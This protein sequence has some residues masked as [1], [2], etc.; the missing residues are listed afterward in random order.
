MITELDIEMK[1]DDIVE[2]GF[3]NDSQLVEKL[4]DDFRK[5]VLSKYTWDKKLYVSVLINLIRGDVDMARE[6]VEAYVNPNIYLGYFTLYGEY[7][8]GLIEK[9]DYSVGFKPID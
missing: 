4:V 6:N 7:L 9:L 8:K 3:S 2:A 5:N 1:L